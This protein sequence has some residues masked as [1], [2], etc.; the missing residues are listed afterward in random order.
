MKNFHKFQSAPLAVISALALV[1][2]LASCDSDD[3][4]GGGGGISVK[5]I[6]LKTSSGGDY[7]GT[8]IEQTLTGKIAVFIDRMPV[9][10]N[11]GSIGKISAD[12]K[13]TLNLPDSIPDNKL[14]TPEEMSATLK[15]GSLETIPYI[16]PV[17]K[18]G[19][20]SYIIMYMNKDYIYTPAGKTMAFKKGWNFV[21]YSAF[22]V[23]TDTEDMMWFIDL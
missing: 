2:A 21:R 23:T 20:D 9:Y 14:Y 12:G 10:Y 6:P 19:E 11:I 4:T 5:D 7:S 3:S 18:D 13:L 16:Y 15:A 1:F 8:G 22:E 17:V